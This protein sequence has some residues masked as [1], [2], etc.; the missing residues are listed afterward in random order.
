[1]MRDSNGVVLMLMKAKKKIHE[2]T[3]FALV[4]GFDPGFDPG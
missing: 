1:M 3:S 2:T 4:S